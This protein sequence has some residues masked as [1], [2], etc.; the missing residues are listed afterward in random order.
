MVRRQ[1]TEG[2]PKMSEIGKK[3]GVEMVFV[4]I[5]MVDHK[6]FMVLKVP[7]FEVARQFLVESR[8]IQ[9]NTIHIYPTVSFEE[10]MKMVE[11]IPPPF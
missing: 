7:S 10:S 4:G 11:A 3:M 1:M 5:P 6:I 2:F 9:T 8:I